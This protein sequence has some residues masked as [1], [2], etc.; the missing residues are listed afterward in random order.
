MERKSRFLGAG[1]IHAMTAENLLSAQ[2]RMFAGATP[3]AVASIAE[4]NG[5]EFAHHCEVADTLEIPTYFCNPYVAWQQRRNEHFKRQIRKYLLKE[6][7]FDDLIQEEPDE[8]VAK[9][10]RRPRK[11]SGVVQPGRNISRPMPG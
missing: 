8:S 2:H 11:F 1:K 3:H 7:R 9:M 10:S 5:S 4:D 6:T